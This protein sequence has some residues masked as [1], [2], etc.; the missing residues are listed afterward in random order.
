MMWLKEADDQ[1]P[2][3]AD[4]TE[5]AYTSL[6]AKALKTR[7][8]PNTTGEINVEMKHLYD[9]W[10][11]FLCRNFNP[12]MYADFREYA[13][14]DAAKS[15]FEGKESLISYYEATLASK[16]KVIPDALA[17]DYV[18]LVKDEQQ[19]LA[20]LSS[21]DRP[22]FK[23]LRAQW[24]NGALDMKSRKKIGTL[25]DSELTKELES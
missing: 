4:D 17:E 6:L 5:E 2:L 1:A 11:H 21:A 15:L 19:Q 3:S 10:S 24:R 22:A 12:K 7:A 9:F 16:K 8:L 18:Q 25:F 23:A 14:E 13:Y 20:S